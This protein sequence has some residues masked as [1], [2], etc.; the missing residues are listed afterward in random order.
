ME[1]SVC[2]VLMVDKTV[3]VGMDVYQTLLSNLSYPH[4]P[5]LCFSVLYSMWD[6]YA[7]NVYSLPIWYFSD[8]LTDV[9][10][11]HER[12]VVDMFHQFVA[13]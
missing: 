10:R 4:F 3:F 5:K 8:G 13:A 9:C 2:G 12:N 1:T 11:Q 6:E 7:A